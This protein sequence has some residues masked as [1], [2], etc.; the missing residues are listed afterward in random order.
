MEN[1]NRTVKLRR[2]ASDDKSTVGPVGGLFSDDQDYKSNR[3]NTRLKNRILSLIVPILFVIF[4]EILATIMDNP[5]VLPSFTSV[6]AILT[7]PTASLLNIGSLANN[8]FVSFLRVIVGYS[9][10]VI[11]GV[12]LGALM[13][14][15]P[16]AN[17][18]LSSFLGIFRP[19]PPL[20]WVPLVLAWFG[21]SSMAMFYPS[22]SGQIYLYLRSLRLSMIFIIFIGAFF[23]I[24]TSTIYG[25]TNVRKILVESTMTL[26]GTKKDIILKIIIPSA[27]PSIING[28]RIGMGVAWMCLVS[29]EML[30]G[31]VAGVGYLITHAYQLARTDIVISGMFTIGLVGVLLD[32]IFRLLE[33]KK[34]QWQ[35]NVQ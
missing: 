34:Y 33:E 21:I 13:G 18:M 9:F 25:V 27:M 30:P 29:A 11:L 17:K 26:G 5:V 22:D 15:S 1:Q 12:P 19:I 28:L 23:P 4:W 3:M 7:N 14:Y 35:K 6:L 20:A 2:K 31:S 8:L 10:A 32:S 16:L 24:L